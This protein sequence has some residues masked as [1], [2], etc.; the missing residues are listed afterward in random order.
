[1]RTSP[2]NESCRR[3]RSPK[4]SGPRARPRP[5]WTDC[6]RR[7]CAVAPP[8]P[9]VY[10]MLFAGHFFDPR[11]PP[12]S[13]AQFRRVLLHMTRS[14]APPIKPANKMNNSRPASV[15]WRALVCS[16]GCKLKNHMLTMSSCPG[17]AICVK[18]RA[19]PR[20]PY[21]SRRAGGARPPAG[22]RRRRHASEMLPSCAGAPGL[23]C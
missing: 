3:A 7:V 2:R 17:P 16:G 22:E 10:F 8:R 5:I 23:E 6:V 19:A 4:Q 9:P 11:A 18:C 15:C 1:V 21:C 20:R 14:R 13:P 12:R